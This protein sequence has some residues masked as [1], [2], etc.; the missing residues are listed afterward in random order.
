MRVVLDGE[1]VEAFEGLVGFDC[2]EKEEEEEREER[3]SAFSS[4]S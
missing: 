2:G 3:R 1:V 4:F